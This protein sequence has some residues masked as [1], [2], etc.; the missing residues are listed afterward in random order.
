MANRYRI[1][2]SRMW[3]D[4]K[5]RRLTHPQPCGLSLWVYLLTGPHTTSIPGLFVAGEMSLAEALGWP[6][7]GFREGFRELLREGL[8]KADWAARVVWIPNAIKCNPPANP[9]VVKG[10]LSYLVEIPEC[11]LKDE[12]CQHFQAF[13]ASKGPKFEKAFKGSAKASA[14]GSAKGSR[15]GMA[16]QE[17]EQEQEQELD[18]GASCPETPPAASSVPPILVFPTDG[19][20]KEWPLVAAKVAEL[21]AA[22]P[23]LDI[24]AECRKALGW[25]LAAPD[26]RKTAKGMSKFLFGWMSR[27]QDRGGGKRGQDG[28]RQTVGRSSRIEAPSGKYAGLGKTIGA[29]ASASADGGAAPG[30]SPAAPNFDT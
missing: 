4:E 2:E 19:R 14:K 26:R 16:N 22:F 18:A 17:Q 29:D 1:I 27:C 25:V 5:I 6:I 28:R 24:L 10:W 7:E 13:L 11:S 30:V 21:A 20:I 23:S 3:G 15:N 12:A 9:N 8:A